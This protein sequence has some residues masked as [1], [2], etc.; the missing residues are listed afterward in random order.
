M[1]KKIIIS[2][3][4]VITI[5]IGVIFGFQ[6]TGKIDREKVHKA[7]D[8]ISD[9]I[10]TYN[11]TN[12]DIEALPTTKIEA[13][14]EEQEKATEQEVENEGFK[15]QGNIAYEGDRARSWGVTL[16]DYKA[17]TFFS[18]IDNRWR[19]K[20]YSS[21]GDSSQT[22]GS[23]GCGPTSAAMIVTATKGA[24]TPDTMA[25]LFVQYGYRSA[26]QGTYWS[27]FRA[28]ADEFN[29]GYEETTNIQ[30]ALQLID[31]NR[32]AVVSCG[33]G[34]FTTGGHFIVIVGKEENNLKIYDPYLY[35]GKFDTSTR[36]GKVWVSGNTVYCPV[37][38]FINYANAKGFFC[39][40]YDEKVPENNTKPVTVDTYT[41]YVKVNTALNVRT[42]PW[43]AIVGSLSNGTAVT[44]YEVRDNWSRIGDNRWVCS[45]Y[46][47]S[48]INSGVQSTVGQTKK[49]TRNCTLYSNSNLTGT[50]YSYRANTT[51]T[52][53][54]NV[55][56]NIDYIKVNATGRY[57]YIDNSN[58]TNVVISSARTTAGQ[59]RK[60]KACILYS[61]SNLTGTRYTY[62]A[63]TTITILK[64]INN[65][66]D[67]IRVNQTGRY[68]HINV[69]NYK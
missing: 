43:G 44:V 41:R 67:Y 47:V 14:T 40:A 48:T 10:E 51:I 69:N 15:L 65:S 3:F 21:I 58:Y 23:S 13:Q 7:V 52:I 25:D 60:T 68:A 56:S 17:L 49:L 34:L 35:A 46:L 27:A 45:D 32:L 26:N 20:M 37:E 36:R 11:M 4:S 19:Y 53:I 30:R 54:K 33:N 16:G 64:H 12:E 42:A 1:K 31:N 66:V 24:I 61:N 55:S 29:I 63:N 28:V 18:Q 50:R 62:K 39:Y 6:E 9:T 38:N 2:I 22:I 5:M 59:T 57:A 8:I